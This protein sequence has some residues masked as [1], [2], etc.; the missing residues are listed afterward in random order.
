MGSWHPGSKYPEQSSH[1]VPGNA[2]CECHFLDPQALLVFTQ[3]PVLLDSQRSR[4]NKHIDLDKWN[5]G[6]IQKR[7]HRR[8]GLPIASPDPEHEKHFKRTENSTAGRVVCVIYV[9]PAA[10][11]FSFA[12]IGS[13]NQHVRFSNLFYSGIWSL[14]DTFLLYMESPQS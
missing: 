3:H 11:L 8:Q 10:V 6:A 13:G 4:G 7:P 1:T 5:S 9:L 14:S 12:N 2:D